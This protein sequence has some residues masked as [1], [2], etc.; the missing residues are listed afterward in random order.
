MTKS[1]REKIRGVLKPLYCIYGKMDCQICSAICG[2][3]Q[4]L[5][6]IEEIIQPQLERLDEENVKALLDKP[7][8]QDKHTKGRLL[9]PY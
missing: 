4:A 8:Y 5:K 1:I 2:I 7:F 6:E 9:K 3:T